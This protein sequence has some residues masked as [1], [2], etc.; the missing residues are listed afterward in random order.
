MPVTV[1]VV[2][3]IG[4][5]AAARWA[6]P[7]LLPRKAVAVAGNDLASLLSG[8]LGGG[9]SGSG[10]LLASLLGSLGDF[11]QG[12]GNPLQGL[13]RE[14][15][16]GGL[17][18]QAQS[19]VGTGANQSVSGPEIAQA[20]PYQSLERIAQQAGLTPEEAADQLAA[21]LPQAVDKLTPQG[22]V[23]QGSMEDLIA[24]AG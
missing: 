19:W 20:V 23:P 5:V 9:Q 17:G 3:V 15:T 18:S 14:L 2:Q 12:G 16:E 6:G 11:G 8:M 4:R 10:S 24:Q 13:V 21:V 22:E 1:S 7:G